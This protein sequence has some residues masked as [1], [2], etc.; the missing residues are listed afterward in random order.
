MVTVETTIYSIVLCIST[1]IKSPDKSRILHELG[2]FKTF[3][4]I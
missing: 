2:N 4:I 3:W 1:I